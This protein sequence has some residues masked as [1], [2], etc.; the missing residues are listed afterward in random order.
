MT[1]LEKQIL[2]HAEKEY[3]REC[4]GIVVKNGDKLEYVECENI[5]DY[6]E[7]FFEIDPLIWL[8]YLQSDIVAIVHSHPDGDPILSIPDRQMQLQTDLDWW[9]VC[10]N[11]IY[12]FRNVPPLVGREFNHGTLDCY[13][14]FRD[15]YMMSG[16][17]FP[18]FYREDEW[19]WNGENLYLDN[20]EKYD[21]EKVDIS[22]IQVG[23]VLLMQVQSD[24][25][26][27]VGIYIGNQMFIHHIPTRLSRR[28]LLGGY[29]LKHT[30]S[31]WR[32]KWNSQLDFTAIYNDL[33]QNLN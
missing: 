9:L 22:Q 15:S 4:C 1:E 8:N 23:D 10:N 28:E 3:P 25:P 20:M 30:H 31:V 5:A 24:V 19:W 14:I 32:Y 7:Q 17:D 18:D 13:A 6:P 12:K 2:L 33:A 26:N 21:F 16:I 11:K 29:Y 27:H